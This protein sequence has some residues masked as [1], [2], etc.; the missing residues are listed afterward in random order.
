MILKVFQDLCSSKIVIKAT[1]NN[2]HLFKQGRRHES[3]PS[4]CPTME[5][6]DLVF[7]VTGDSQELTLRSGECGSRQSIQA[8]PDHPNREVPQLICT[9]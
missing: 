1:D 5:N 2:C 4:L 8:G 9:K 6:T 3:E 7:K